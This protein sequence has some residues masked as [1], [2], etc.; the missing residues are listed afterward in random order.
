MNRVESQK[1]TYMPTELHSLASDDKN[2]LSVEELAMSFGEP[3]DFEGHFAKKPR[4]HRAHERGTVG[5]GQLVV[6]RLI[7]DIEQ[8][9]IAQKR[10][11]LP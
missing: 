7:A 11:I 5:L 1:T 2:L 10:F 6:E 9:P 4:G 8:V 3:K